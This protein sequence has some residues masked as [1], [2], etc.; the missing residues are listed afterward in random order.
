MVRCN[1]ENQM[2]KFISITALGLISLVASI[3]VNAG[4]MP[5]GS[6]DGT[7]TRTWTFN[8]ATACD[9]G[10]GNPNSTSDITDLGGDF[11]GT[12]WTKEGDVTDTGDNSSLL[13]VELT[14]GTWGGKD[15]EGTW[16]LVDDFWSWFDEAVFTVHVGGNWQSDPDDFG[17]FVIEENQLSGTWSFLQETTATNGGGGGGGLS[18][19]SIWT[20]PHKVPEPGILAL[21]GLGLLGL[22]FA[23]RRTHI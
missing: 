14:S 13:D 16:T 22:G 21:F 2:G 17:A 15:I 5:C 8:S 18:N 7:V 12:T 1:T 23:R 3:Q 19:V 4:F 6:T 11:A 20:G 10:P 9:S